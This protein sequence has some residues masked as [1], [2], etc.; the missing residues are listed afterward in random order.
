MHHL[1]PTE[2]TGDRATVPAEGGTVKTDQVKLAK[3]T[4]QERGTP[5][6]REKRLTRARIPTGSGSSST[7]GQETFL[8]AQAAG[9]ATG[10]VTPPGHRTI[11]SCSL[12]DDPSLLASLARME[13]RFHGIDLQLGVLTQAQSSGTQQARRLHR[14]PTPVR[15]HPESSETPPVQIPESTNN[16]GK[17]TVSTALVADRTFSPFGTFGYSEL[18]SD[19][20]QQRSALDCLGN[21]L[22]ATMPVMNP[23]SE[24]AYVAPR[25]TQFVNTGPPGARRK[26]YA[27]ITNH[28]P[29]SRHSFQA[30]P[31]LMVKPEPGILVV[32][33]H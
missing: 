18:E 14:T 6:P 31:N 24:V 4:Q 27:R 16:G 7:S 5:P 21:V 9:G 29:V 11:L 28:S 20:S 30:A 25:G 33:S 10:S 12:S 26:P 19:P 8:T 3:T 15:L 13:A 1:T 23:Q 32:P 2:T 22:V 17:A